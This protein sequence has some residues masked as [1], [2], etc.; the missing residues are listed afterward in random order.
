MKNLK[1]EVIEFRVE[2]MRLMYMWPVGME[3]NVEHSHDSG[4]VF[5]SQRLLIHI[6][7]QED[8][9]HI[10]DIVLFKSC[11]F[12]SVKDIKFVKG[13]LSSDRCGSEAYD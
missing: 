6:D 3:G 2:I 7:T 4:H 8:Q 1:T 12:Q 11:H 13:I 5:T 10:D 9:C